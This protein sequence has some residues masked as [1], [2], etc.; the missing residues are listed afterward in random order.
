MEDIKMRIEGQI[1]GTGSP[2]GLDVDGEKK[3]DNPDKKGKRKR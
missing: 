2:P 1:S 3:G